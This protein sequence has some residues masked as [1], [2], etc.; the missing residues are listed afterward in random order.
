[1]RGDEGLED[2]AR[3]LP[4]EP[5]LDD[6][7]PR[8]GHLAAGEHLVQREAARQERREAETTGG[9]RVLALGVAVQG[10]VA[11][12]ERKAEFAITFGRASDG[13]AL[14]GQGEAVLDVGGDGGC[15]GPGADAR[16]AAIVDEA[17]GHVAGRT[18]GVHAVVEATTQVEV[19]FAVRFHGFI[20]NGCEGFDARSGAQATRRTT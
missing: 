18:G 16:Q 12:G 19:G 7:A 10:V 3:C 2:G 17:A 20:S 13:R 9:R 5:V 4:G 15:H 14:G 8:A 1:M 11:E 6:G